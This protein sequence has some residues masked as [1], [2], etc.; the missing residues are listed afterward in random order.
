MAARKKG[1]TTIGAA[2]EKYENKIPLMRSNYVSGVS[3]FFGQDVSGSVPVKDYLAKVT[4]GKGAY[5][6]QQLK[7]SFGIGV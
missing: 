3:R 1:K 6:A 4:P 5:W 2:Q 7:K